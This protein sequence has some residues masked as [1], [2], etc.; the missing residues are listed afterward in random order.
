MQFKCKIVS[1][2]EIKV[3]VIAGLVDEFVCIF[4]FQVLST[5]RFKY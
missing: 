2:Q 4:E 1:E 5:K 3:G